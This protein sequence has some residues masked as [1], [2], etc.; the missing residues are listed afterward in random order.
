MTP[1]LHVLIATLGSAG[2][3][4]PFLALGQALHA[5]GHRVTV[6]CP[7]VFGPLVQQA[8]LGFGAM[9]STA[10]YEAV[11]QEPDLW[12][13]RKGFGVIW[14]HLREG[15]RLLPDHVQALPPDEPLLLVCHPL[16]LASADLCRAQRPGLRI[17]GAYL[18]PQNLRTVHHPLTLGPL[19]VPAWVPM[20]WRRWAWRRID[21]QLIDP[22]TVPDLN[23]LRRECG[24][25]P[26]AHFVAHL[27]AVPDLTATLFAPWFGPAQ[28]DWPQPRVEGGFLLYDRPSHAAL[29]PELQRF[30]AAGPPPLV[31]T[32]GTGHRHAAGYFRAA[33]Q[34]VQALGR[35]AVFLTGHPEQLPAALPPE[36]LAQAYASF[37]SLLPQA[38]A[39]VHH[40][41]IGSTAEALRAGVPQLVVP[42]AHDQF[43]NA[44]RVRALGVGDALPARHASP[45]RLRRRLQA[46]LDR[47]DLAAHCATLA[48]Q[49][50]TDRPLPRLC[51]AIEALARVQPG[52][53]RLK[54]GGEAS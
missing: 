20:A 1:P 26:I 21:Q 53:A 42:F 18:A 52:E 51:D 31:F 15:L 17:V 35:R 6:L 14:R 9:G 38:A 8:G 32:P 5:R 49:A 24:L 34:A 29:S 30:L 46:L 16:A 48:A 54:C 39:L 13:V 25:P 12:D 11:T 36:V 44:R 45:A 28:P 4:H 37:R 50:A 3:I 22:L 47:P 27:Q 7:E 41:G 10:Q 19:A 23:A 33:L 43:D 40:G 2:D